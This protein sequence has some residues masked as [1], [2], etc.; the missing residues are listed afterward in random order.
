M[1]P[2]GTKTSSAYLVGPPD[3]PRW[4]KRNRGIF[5]EYLTDTTTLRALGEKHGLSHE[6]IRQIIR[7]QR[8]ISVGEICKRS[9]T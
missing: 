9:I 7:Q 6:R 3:D 5:E 8:K 1:T 2:A 4:A